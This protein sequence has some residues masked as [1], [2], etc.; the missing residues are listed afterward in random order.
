MNI[1]PEPAPDGGGAKLVAALDYIARGWRVVPLHAPVL[2]V[3]GPPAC[4]CGKPDC[5]SVGKHPRTRSGLKAATADADVIG[6]W[7]AK[8]PDT[9]GRGPILTGGHQ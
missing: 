3:S 8:W 4:S 7:W 1:R 9:N 6:G 5:G 2:A